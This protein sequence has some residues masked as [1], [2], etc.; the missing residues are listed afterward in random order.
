MY[1]NGGVQSVAHPIPPQRVCECTIITDNFTHAQFLTELHF[2]PALL[3][4]GLTGPPVSRVVSSNIL[5][6][7]VVKRLTGLSVTI[8]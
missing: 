7:A 2:W 1:F 8:H 6:T 3:Q 4:T 5:S